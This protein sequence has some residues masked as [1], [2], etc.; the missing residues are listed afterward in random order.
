MQEALA[1]KLDMQAIYDLVG[2]KIQQLFN[3]QSVIIESLDLEKQLSHFNYGYENG[4]H[5]SDDRDR[6]QTH[7]HR[8]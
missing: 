4:E 5:L 3:A 1:S 7:H 2:D 8:P 6:A